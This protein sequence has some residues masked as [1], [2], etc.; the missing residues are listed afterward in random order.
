MARI[1]YLFRVLSDYLANADKSCPHCGNQQTVLI[2]RKHV[3]LQL[4][5]CPECQLMFRYPKDTPSRNHT[6]YSRFY[7]ENGITT[8]TP[9]DADLM[10][11]LETSFAKTGKDFSERISIL[12]SYRDTGELLDYGSSWC[13]GSWQLLK[14]GYRVTAFEIDEARANYGREKLGIDVHSNW[15]ALKQSHQTFDV[16][17]TSHVLEHLPD[18]GQ[19]FHD[20]RDMLAPNGLLM[21]LVPNSTGI[22]HGDVFNRKKSFAFG[23][24]HTLTFTADFFRHNLPQYGF[25]LI[26]ID[27]APYSESKSDLIS[28]SEL[29]IIASKDLVGSQ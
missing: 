2:G 1:A 14:A 11:M 13:Y 17:F 26:R 4:R 15:D 9:S 16:I 20:F 24:K 27:T 28:G 23:E 18:L 8:D 3:I 7:R 29:L 12:K 6:F 25:S 19:T 5:N 10:L 22:Q 21:I